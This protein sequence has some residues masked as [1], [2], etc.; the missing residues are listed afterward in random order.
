LAAYHELQFGRIGAERGVDG[1]QA[2]STDGSSPPVSIT[3][4]A[5][6]RLAW[7]REMAVEIIALPYPAAKSEYRIIAAPMCH[8]AAAG[9]GG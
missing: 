2:K 6:Q 5:N 8:K 7:D 4:N 9:F 3:A 1:G